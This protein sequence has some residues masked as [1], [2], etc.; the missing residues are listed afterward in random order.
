MCFYLSYMISVLVNLFQS[1]ALSTI[2]DENDKL[3][4][5]YSYSFWGLRVHF[6]CGHNVCTPVYYRL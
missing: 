5:N 4:L 2:S 3:L 6:L 1:S